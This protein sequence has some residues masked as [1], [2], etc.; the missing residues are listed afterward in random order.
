[1]KRPAITQ[2]SSSE[3]V[4]VEVPHAEPGRVAVEQDQR[5]ERGRAD[6]V[7]LR[8]GLRRVA[9]RVERVGDRAH[10]LVEIRHLGDAA[11]VVGHRAVRV[12]RDDQAGHREL[13]HHRDADP[14]EAGEVVRDEDPGRD[15]DHRQ[16][17][18]LH[19]DGEALDDVRRVA[20][21][22]GR[23]DLLHRAPAG[24]RVELGDRDEQEGDDQADERREVEV[25]EAE[26]ARV[27][28]EHDRDEADRREHGGDEDRLVERVH[29][30]AVA[31][32]ACEEGADHRGEDRDAADR[33]REQLEVQAREGLR[34]EQHHG[35]RGDGVGLEQVGGHAGAV[36]DVVA[37]VVGDHGRVARVVLGDPGLDLA[38]QVGADVGGL[39][40]DA[41][42][43]S[44]EDR[45]QRAAE[46]EPDEVV[47][48]RAAACGRASR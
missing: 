37:D 2:A 46:G 8:D 17:R 34:G 21:A 32:D 18:R 47:D 4:T 10:R 39:R 42:A 35:H 14:V 36:A 48:R 23:G 19:A 20:G 11:R 26:P 12:E 31:P 25:P 28:G 13:R 41:A 38:D 24:A 33:E 40:V 1:M 3:K 6:R 29:D 16:G 5:R 30:R 22:R 45:D 44:R 43:E 15:H 7:A 9:D 27:V